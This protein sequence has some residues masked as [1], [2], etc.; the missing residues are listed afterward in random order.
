MPLH[1]HN[2]K[3]ALTY[4]DKFQFHGFRLG[5]ERMIS[6]LNA[7][8]NPEKNY[9][10]LHVAGTNGKGSVSAIIA[11]ILH[12]AG[13]RTG[14]YTSPHLSSLRERFRIGNTMISE[15]E[16][17]ERIWRIR[18]F[19]ERGYELSYFEFTTAIAMIWFEEQETDLAIFETG[20]GGRLDAT[21]IVTPLVSVITNISLEHQ[22]F[23]GS[24]ISEI[25]K[26]KAGIIK[27][28]VPVI[29]GVREQPALSVILDRCLDLNAPI[30]EL[31]R[32]FD[33][34]EQGNSRIDYKGEFL[35]ING[36]DLALK[37]THQATNAGLA[38]AACERLIEQGFRVTDTAVR[39]GCRSVYWPGR[40]ELLKGSCRVLLDGAHNL[41]G[42]R[43]LKNLLGRLNTTSIDKGRCF[44]SLLWACSDEGGDKD[45]VAMLRQIASLFGQ[46][47]ITEP[48][49]PRVP[50]TLERWRRSDI[51]KDLTLEQ[52]WRKALNKIL[53]N[54]G[55]ED[56]LCVAGSLYLIG[57][58]REE[59]MERE[60]V[61]I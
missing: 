26:E 59:L 28:G 47:I 23:L 51:P 24:S 37:G 54:C 16:L 58:V 60:F 45:F 41:G 55:K 18:D 36:L 3:T 2:F 27:K 49:G 40:G 44:H 53:S 31:G 9:P 33:V 11:S 15:E 39:N 38:I 1:K 46:I 32:D 19:L 29:T 48:P 6:I 12:S 17:K 21:N 14:L 57:A 7:F 8:G 56:L 50:V 42:L 35:K 13:Y 34:K 52:N 43:S 61:C 20:L 4:L 10:C 30:W 5:L 25:A 22:A